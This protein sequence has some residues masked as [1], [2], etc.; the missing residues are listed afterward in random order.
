MS[1][2]VLALGAGLLSAVN[3]WTSKVLVTD[4][5]R[6]VVVGGVVHL[7]AG[8]VCLVILPLA[9]YIVPLRGSLEPLI[10]L[11]VLAMGAVYVLAN[12]LYFS[13]LKQAELSEIDLF[14]RTSSLWTFILGVV[15]LSEPAGPRTALGAALVIGSVLLLSNQQKGLLFNRA[16]L[17]ALGA[18]LAFAAGNVID[19]VLSPAFDA[20]SYTTLNLLLTG[21]GML[22]IARAKKSEIVASELRGG[23]ALTVAATFALTQLLIILAF[24]A[25][26]SAG[27]VILVAQ[28]RLLILLTVGIVLLKER[29][30]MGRKAVAALLMLAGIAALYGLG[31]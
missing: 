14:L 26:G 5:L 23:V 27:E 12:S 15:L 21:A 18:A 10:L 29:Q 4:N 19:K 22:L 13:A 24:A 31:A 1:W 17:L 28:V 9:G 16:Q 30:R 2:F 7:W 6:P 25:G 8:L 20:L 11:A 3:V